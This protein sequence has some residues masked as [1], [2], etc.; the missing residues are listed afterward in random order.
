MTMPTGPP[1]PPLTT[2][3]SQTVAKVSTS[4]I[5][6]SFNCSWFSDV[7]GVIKWFAVIVLESQGNNALTLSTNPNWFIRMALQW[8]LLLARC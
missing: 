5:T 6:F 3:V 4:S 8:V 7:N 1:S 2:R